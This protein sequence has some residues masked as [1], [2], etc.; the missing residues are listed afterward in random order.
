MCTIAIRVRSETY[1]L[2]L[3]S[4]GILDSGAAKQILSNSFY[5]Y[6]LL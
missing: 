3:T 2:K 1:G 4:S 6:I 5:S